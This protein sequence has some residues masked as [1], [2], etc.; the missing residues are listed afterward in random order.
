MTL[1]RALTAGEL[2]V[3]N[4]DMP[5]ILPAFRT[6]LIVL[7]GM[8]ANAVAQ[9]S[10]VVITGE[11]A[12]L[13]IAVSQ[14]GQGLCSTSKASSSPGTDFPQSASGFNSGIN[15]F[16]DGPGSRV[17]YVQRTILDLSNNNTAS[18]QL[19]SYGDFT[20]SSP[21][22]LIGGC[23]FFVNDTTTSFA[24]RFRG[25]LNVTPEMTQGTLHIGFYADDAVSLV[26]YDKTQN[27]YPVITRPPQI[28]AATWRSTNTVKFNTPGLYPIEILYTQIVEHAA[29]EMSMLNG[30]FTDFE[31]GASTS[32]ADSL[33]GAGFQLFNFT[34]FYQAEDGQPTHPDPNTCVQCSR[35]FANVPGNGGCGAGNYCNG[36]A[37]C[38]P[39][40]SSF[41][42]GPSCAP[43]SG[44]TPV[45]ATVG[46]S[47]RCV[48]C[49]KDTDC[50]T[51]QKCNVDTN[52][53]Q[54]CNVNADCPRGR[55]CN[56]GRC[57]TCSSRNSCAGASCNCCP[58]PST[59]KCASLT[60]GAMPSCVECTQDSDCSG[61]LKCDTVNG[62]CIERIPDCNTAD[63]CGPQCVRCPSER[64]FCLD[65]QVC[66]EC[67]ADFECAAGKFC[68]SGE[69]TSCTT[70]R[71][72]GARCSA[73]G[74]D[75][76]Y[77]K[78][79]GTMEHSACVRCRDDVDCPGGR[80]DPNTN[81]CTTTCAMTCSPGTYCDGSRCVRCYA[82]T[83]CACG[84]ACEAN[85]CTASCDASNDCSGVEHCTAASRT[86][87]RGR[88]KPGVEPKGGGI[89]CG[90]SAS[91]GRATDGL[92]L[93][94]LA[95]ILLSRRRGGS[96]R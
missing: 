67:R 74:G 39:C 69:C 46:G 58:G 95:A 8:A 93:L 14:P 30:T 37:L 57:E 3:A 51:G 4:V 5:R 41:F 90:I 66:V 45:C 64:P 54:E 68:L 16:I 27:A 18:S 82:N 36:A 29:L 1:C 28:G 76:P 72:C 10:P 17:T 19:N 83:H 20:N 85:E 13:P 86:C 52:E 50:R 55:T 80:C 60:P 71:H 26:I 75:T 43:C 89:C 22:C 47:T 48:Q 84:G 42:C 65:G 12:A 24:T 79:D 34:D 94:S 73:C 77:C 23:G 11:P 62:R 92:V 7:I 81:T 87:E 49:T 61:G 88:S 91:T 25:Y 35:Q 96:R 70:D 21:A 2:R 33:K 44:T 78:S 38:A 32:G 53:C 6:A 40:T 9:P 59:L 31:R 56:G 15:A 63:R